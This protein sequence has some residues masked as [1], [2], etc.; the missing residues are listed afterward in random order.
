MLGYSSERPSNLS[1]LM[2]DSDHDGVTDRLSLSCLL[3]YRQRAHPRVSELRPA[4]GVTCPSVA[5]GTRPLAPPVRKHSKSGL[6]AAWPGIGFEDF[7]SLLVRAHA[8]EW[9][10]SAVALCVAA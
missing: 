9:R 1:L 7:C 10:L 3:L 6:A 5:S 8:R 4:V 2:P